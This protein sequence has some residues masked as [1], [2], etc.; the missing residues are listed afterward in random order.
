M[1]HTIVI[2]SHNDSAKPSDKF[3]ARERSDKRSRSVA[4]KTDEMPGMVNTE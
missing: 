3:F 4:R 1:D 2:T